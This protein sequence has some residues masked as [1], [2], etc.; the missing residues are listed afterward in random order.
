[1]AA[2]SLRIAVTIKRFSESFVSVDLVVD[3]EMQT[4]DEVLIQRD[5]CAAAMVTSHVA[6]GIVEK[7]W[8]QHMNDFDGGA[9]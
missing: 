8:R 2:A 7:W 4:M 9:T 3:G 5:G 6:A 1:M